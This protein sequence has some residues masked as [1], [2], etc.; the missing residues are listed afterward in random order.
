MSTPRR[1][2]LGFAIGA[3]LT[4]SVGFVPSIYVGVSVVVTFY[5]VY[6]LICLVALAVLKLT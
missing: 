2:T 5:I 6:A 3:L 4:L 1:L